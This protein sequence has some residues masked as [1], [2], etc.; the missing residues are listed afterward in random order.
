M[1]TFVDY[2]RVRNSLSIMFANSN[3]SFHQT[4]SFYLLYLII[5]YFYRQLSKYCNSLVALNAK[6]NES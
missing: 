2:I 4:E 5:I 3:I 1:S 6:K